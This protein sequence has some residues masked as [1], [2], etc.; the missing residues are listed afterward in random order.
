LGRQK[1]FL[2]SLSNLTSNKKIGILN[3]IWLQAGAVEPTKIIVLSSSEI[4]SDGVPI[5]E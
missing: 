5:E 4:Q 1:K 3:P 2:S